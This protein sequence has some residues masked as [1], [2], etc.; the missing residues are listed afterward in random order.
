VGQNDF[1]G[2]IHIPLANCTLDETEEFQLLAK[3]TK[4]DVSFSIIFNS[5]KEILC[6]F[7]F[8]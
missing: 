3:K 2:E 7:F 4:K 5:K 1:L 8:F 6:C